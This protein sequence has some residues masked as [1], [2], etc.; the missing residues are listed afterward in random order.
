MAFLLTNTSGGT[1]TIDDLGGRQFGAAVT[2][3][4]LSNEF[5]DE[6]IR[7]S[8]SLATLLDASDITGKDTTYEPAPGKSITT[9]TELALFALKQDS[10]DIGEGSTN[11]YATDGNV[12]AALGNLS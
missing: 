11:L 6:E 3:F 1:I 8:S 4:N 12:Q 10:D 9:S 7:N 2:D 5:T